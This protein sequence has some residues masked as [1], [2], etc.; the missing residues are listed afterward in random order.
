MARV[1]SE[2][3]F[4]YSLRLAPDLSRN[5]KLEIPHG[6]S[7]TAI[8]KQSRPCV[9]EFLIQDVDEDVRG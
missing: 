7:L 3:L 9:D 1:V 5:R 6:L 2:L 4:T 8:A